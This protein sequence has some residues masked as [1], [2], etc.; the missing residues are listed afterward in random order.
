MQMGGG[1]PEGV[2]KK[3][4]EGFLDRGVHVLYRPLCSVLLKSH[5]RPQCGD[6][7]EFTN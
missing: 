2:Q 6:G 3:A 4:Q 7:I 1:G 5:V